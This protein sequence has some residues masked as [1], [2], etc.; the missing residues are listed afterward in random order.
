MQSRTG[1]GRRPK[2]TPD[3]LTEFVKLL[4]E[5]NYVYIVCKAVGIGKTSYHAWRTKGQAATSGIYREFYEQ[6]EQATA[7]AEGNYLGI[8]KDAAKSGTWQAA[9]WYL[10]R[11]YPE[12]WGRRD[13]RDITS[14]GKPLQKLDLSKLSNDEL[15]TIEKLFSVN[16]Q[17][18]KLAVDPDGESQ[19]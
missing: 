13:Y 18:A 2:L 19:T 3:L 17:P 11:R 16:G 4:G 6:T 5:G 7:K 1:R 15:E 12:R 10:E 9:A 8:I 14:G